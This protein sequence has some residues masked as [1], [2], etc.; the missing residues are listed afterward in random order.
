MRK[1]KIGHEDS[2][3]AHVCSQRFYARRQFNQSHMAEDGVTRLLAE[4]KWG[5]GL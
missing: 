4:A 3:E 1:L 2:Q 5:K